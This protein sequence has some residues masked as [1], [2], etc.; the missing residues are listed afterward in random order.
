MQRSHAMGDLVRSTFLAA[1]DRLISFGRIL[2]FS[3][4]VF[5]AG[6]LLAI[7]VFEA[8]VNEVPSWVRILVLM[9]WVALLLV[10]VRYASGAVVR[11]RLLKYLM[12]D[13]D[14]GW[15]SPLLLVVVVFWFTTV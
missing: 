14:Y 2:F 13:G 8:D 12:R 5:W 15:L 4:L 7:P 6:G 9:L 10:V 3:V 11:T 1:G